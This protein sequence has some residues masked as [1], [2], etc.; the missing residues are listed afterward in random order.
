MSETNGLRI[1]LSP[2]QLAA[3]LSEKSI[4]EGETF[5]NR[6]SGGLGLIGGMTEMFGAGVMC[7]AP[8]PTMLTKAG[9]V[10]VGTHSLDTLQ[11]S[12]R[13]MWTGRETNTDT[14]NSAVMLAES[15]GA[16]RNTALKVGMTVDLAIPIGFSVAVGAVRVVAVRS[17][18]IKLAE[19]E[20]MTGRHPGGHTIERHIGKTTEELVTRLQRRPNLP[21]ASSFRNLDEAEVLTTKVLRAHKNEIEMF[22][23]FQPKGTPW[24]KKISMQFS[25]PTGIVVKRGSSEA[26]NCY[27]VEVWLELTKYNG[28]P[29]FILTSMPME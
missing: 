26:R 5:S 10:L 1:A 23:K 16:D 18:R 15:L 28:K 19:H 21:A 17:G 24:R 27:R 4:S 25:Q 9:C 22:V 6:L 8:D 7:V 20:S 3:T 12:F 29:Y 14:Y 11:A 13:Q 2:V